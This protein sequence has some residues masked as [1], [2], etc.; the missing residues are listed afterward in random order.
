[1]G[2]ALGAHGMTKGADM[3]MCSVSA[4]NAATCQDMVS[5]GEMMP[6]VDTVNNITVTSEEKDGSVMVT[7]KRKLDTGDAE[8]DFVIPLDSEFEMSWSIMETGSD[9][10]K[11]H[12]KF[13]EINAMLKSDGTVGTPIYI[14]ED[15]AMALAAQIAA[16]ASL[17]AMTMF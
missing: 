1:M 5:V 9:M 8:Q 10:T 3:I 11:E 13:G 2:F 4:A 6:Q 7:V 16:G 14:E 15:G 12:T 17:I